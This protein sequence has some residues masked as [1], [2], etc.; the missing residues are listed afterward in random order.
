[1]TVLQAWLMIGIPGIAV[2][3]ILFLA[4]NRWASAGGY[5]VL[6][7]SM[8]GMA[9]VH[10]PS[11]AGLGIGAALLYAAGKGGSA[12][13]GPNPLAQSGVEAADASADYPQ[14]L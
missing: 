8:A 14:A 9:M 11:A 4:K 1:M 7:A 2:A 13:S 3:L 12:D 5:A 10:R 6:I